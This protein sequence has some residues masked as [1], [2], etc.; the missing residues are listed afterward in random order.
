MFPSDDSALFLSLLLRAILECA[1]SCAMLVR[2]FAETPAHA[3]TG[4]VKT[5]AESGYEQV[6]VSLL[7]RTNTQRGHGW[8]L[9]RQHALS[10]ALARPSPESTGQ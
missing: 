9:Q 7:L 3:F 4:Q 8:A 10:G 2:G 5:T 1:A 6:C